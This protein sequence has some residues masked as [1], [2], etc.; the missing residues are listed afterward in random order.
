MK[1]A[2]SE[3][4]QIEG[5]WIDYL[6]AIGPYSVYCALYLASSQR[7]ALLYASSSFDG[8]SDSKS[9]HR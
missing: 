1:M 8:P 3:D 2:V 5:I 9:E 7:Q 6:L 4:G